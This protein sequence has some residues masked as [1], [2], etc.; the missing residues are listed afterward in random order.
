MMELAHL[1]VHVAYT[2][3]VRL[4]VPEH[5][6]RSTCTDCLSTTSASRM[7]T[8]PCASTLYIACM[9]AALAEP[10]HRF[11]VQ[12]HMTTAETACSSTVSKYCAHR[13]ALRTRSGECS[14][15][16]MLLHLRT[17]VCSVLSRQCVLVFVLDDCTHTSVRSGQTAC[18]HC[19]LR[20]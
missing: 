4:E 16:S 13:V 18:H 15:N 19:S 2:A 5:H 11:L 6:H 3:A 10:S 1:F 7:H 14:S 9:R 20:R 8:I 17:V 12:S